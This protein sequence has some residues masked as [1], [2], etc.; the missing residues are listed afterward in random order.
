[1][2]RLDGLG[3]FDADAAVAVGVQFTKKFG[4]ADELL[5]GH[6]AIARNHTRPRETV[7]AGGIGLAAAPKGTGPK[8][9]PAG[10]RTA[11]SRNDEGTATPQ[12]ACR[13]P[14]RQAG[15]GRPG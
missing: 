5:G 12:A 10:P 11:T 3:L 15:C 9:A 2:L 4:R 8:E 13:G 14:V 6:E 7:G 1:M